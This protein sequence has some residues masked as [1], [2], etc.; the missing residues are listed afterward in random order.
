MQAYIEGVASDMDGRVARLG[1]HVAEA[2]PVW[3]L[4]G[5]G[6]VPS[7]PEARAAWE[8]RAGAVAKYREAFGYRDETEPAGPE[9]GT[10]NPVQRAA[11]YEAMNALGPVDGV[12]VRGMSD[13]ALLNARAVFERETV[14]APRYVADELRAVRAAKVNAELQAV[15][16][17]AEA[18]AAADLKV[19]AAHGRLAE[20][21]RVL[22]AFYARTEIELDE[23]MAV[24]R[25]WA[26][27]SGHARR[28]AI[29]AD[30]EYRRRNPESDLPVLTSAEPEPVSPEE[31]DALLAGERPGWMDRL[32]EAAGQPRRSWTTG[33]ACGSRRRSGG[34][35]RRTC[36]ARDGPPS[37]RRR[38][39]A[40]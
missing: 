9:P 30:S 31:R 2:V 4:H 25:E 24:R 34:R 35:L 3:A 17:D 18:A 27:A 33:A 11:W 5:L 38:A 39:A 12:D 26:E 7:E 37:A 29:A 6:P 20:S 13:G 21:A 15:R 23:Q 22:E 16:A 8:H 19:G 1:H 14:W 40:P 32:A 28:T 36:L 10:A